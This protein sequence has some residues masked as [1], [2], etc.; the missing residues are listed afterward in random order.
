MAIIGGA[1]FIVKDISIV[2]ADS[3]PKDKMLIYIRKP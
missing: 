1:V 2:G 3:L